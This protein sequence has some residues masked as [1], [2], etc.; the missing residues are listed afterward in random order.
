[1]SKVPLKNPNKLFADSACFMVFLFQ[2]GF[3]L[4]HWLWSE[5]LHGRCSFWYTCLRKSFCK[6][7]LTKTR[8][9]TKYTLFRG[10]TCSLS[11]QRPGL[12]APGL[13]FSSLLVCYPLKTQRREPGKMPRASLMWCYCTVSS[14]SLQALS[15]NQVL[16]SQF[17]SQMLSN[18]FLLLQLPC[19]MWKLFLLKNSV[20]CNACITN[21]E[22]MKYL[23]CR[24]N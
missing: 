7:K 3:E 1:M 18:T 17:S 11:R 15:E 14:Q 23:T 22:S 5:S 2:D 24:V 13:L 8:L 6:W 20:W 9:N 16:E 10:L 4:H 21:A 12:W 19:G